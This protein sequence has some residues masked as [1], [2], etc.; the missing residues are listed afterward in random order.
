M[1]TDT[2]EKIKLKEIV[3]SANKK[4]GKKESEIKKNKR[5]IKRSNFQ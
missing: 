4:E 3:K 5:N 1:Q 2:T